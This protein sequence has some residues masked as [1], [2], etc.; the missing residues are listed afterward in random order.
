MNECYV[1]LANLLDGGE[2]VCLSK[3]RLSS[4]YESFDRAYKYLKN[5]NSLPSTMAGPLWLLQLL[6]NVIYSPCFATPS[7]NHGVRTPCGVSVIPI[8]RS[9]HKEDY[10]AA[11]RTYF[12]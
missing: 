5:S 6:L 10:V 7:N 8:T 3:I 9:I 2:N 11:F 4:L 12:V 1:P